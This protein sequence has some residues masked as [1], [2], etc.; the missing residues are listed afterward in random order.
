MVEDLQNICLDWDPCGQMGE[1]SVDDIWKPKGRLVAHVNQHNGAINQVSLNANNSQMVT[2]SDDGSIRI[3][4]TDQF[5][6]HSK[7]SSEYKSRN[8]W[9]S[10]DGHKV[11]RASFTELTRV[12]VTTNTSLHYL[13]TENLKAGGWSVHFD[14]K[15]D[16]I[17]TGSFN[18]FHLCKLQCLGLLSSHILH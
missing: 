17:I 11:K 9:T 4:N 15:K 6:N 10:K 12:A 5:S 7:P 8:N 3:W 2:S 16:G 14:A 1:P 18:L 13:D